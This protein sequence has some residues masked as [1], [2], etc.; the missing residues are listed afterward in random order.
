LKVL[1]FTTLYPNNIWPNHGVFIKER[2]THFAALPG[3]EIKVIAPV[4][5]YPPIKLGARQHYSQIA[6]HQVID[7]I[8]VY[9]P[10]FYMTPKIGM[11]LYGLMMYYSVVKS[12]E[13]LRETFDFDLIDAHYIY[14]DGLAAVLLGKHFKKPVVL[15]AR[16]SD[17]NQFAHFPMIRKLLRYTLSKADHVVAVCDALKRAIVDLNVPAGK[18][19]VIPNGVDVDKFSHVPQE[20]ARR[21]LKLPDQKIILSVGSLIPR[22]GHDLVIKAFKKLVT[23][24]GNVNARLY[25]IGEGEAGKP[26]QQLVHSLELRDRVKLV[27]GV[28]HSDLKFWYNAADLF[29]L[30]SSREGWPNVVMESLACGTPVVATDVWGIPEI[31]TSDEMGLLTKRSVPDIYEK[32]VTGL[33]KKWN[34]K[35]ISAKMQSRTWDRTA[36]SV[37]GVFISVLN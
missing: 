22:K 6:K 26:L 19:T 4:P 13:R 1:V 17:I 31:I 36:V 8:G 16:G 12:V 11:S 2:M 34:N 7:G 33:E 9:H 23:K 29:C 35:M 30:A 27:G 37:K 3:N 18:I 5:Y 32:C 28:P 14:P 25:I 24:N 10:R 15:S 20:L 21:K